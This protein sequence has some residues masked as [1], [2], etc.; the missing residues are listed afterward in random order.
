MQSMTTDYC[1]NHMIIYTG[2]N[3]EAV[4]ELTDTRGDN[5]TYQ[6]AKLAD[7][8]CWMLNNLK[9]G[10]TSGSMLLTPGDT[11]IASNFTLPQVV[12]TG[13][14][15]YD[16]PGAYGPVSGDTGE[17][18]TNYGY[19]YNWS[20]ATA[21]EYRASHDETAGDAPYSICAAGWRLPT[22]RWDTGWEN[23][24]GDFPD[25]DRAFGGSGEGSSNGE[26]NIAQWQH[27][28]AFKGVFSGG[29]D[30]GFGGQGGSLFLW[31]ASAYT[32]SADVAFL[33]YFSSGF[34]VPA[35]Y[36]YRHYGLEVRCLLN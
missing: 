35:D 14:L 9:L 4:I 12:T 10:S 8:N 3:E 11:N 24:S 30:R 28:G 33:A 1:Q 31:S 20:A 34:V 26:P 22:V 29:W 21:G 25:L 7:N 32:G 23:V 27:N 13:A 15:D 6:V 36:D 16:N 18:T 5:Q 19:L 2:S 17:G